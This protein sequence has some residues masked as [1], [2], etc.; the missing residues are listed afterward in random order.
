MK[1]KLFCSPYAHLPARFVFVGSDI[2]VKIMFPSQF[3]QSYKCLFGIRSS[4]DV[5]ETVAFF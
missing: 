1:Q 3:P 2:V 5:S 4:K